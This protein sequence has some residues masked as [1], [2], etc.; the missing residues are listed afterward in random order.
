VVDAEVDEAQRPVL[1]SLMRELTDY[2]LTRYRRR[3]DVAATKDAFVCKLLRNANGDPILKLPPRDRVA[4]PEGERDVRLPDGSVWRFRF[5]KEFCNVAR[6]PGAERNQLPD[7]MRRWFGPTAGAP[8]TSFQLR[9][10]PSPDGLWVEPQTAQ[11]IAFSGTRGTVAAYPDLRAAAG[12]GAS[13]TEAPDREWVSLPI[14]AASDALFAVRVAGNSMDGGRAPLHHGDWAVFRL[15]RGAAPQAVAGRVVLVESPAEASGRR[16]QI[17]RLVHRDG[18]WQLASDNPDGPQLPV[19]EGMIVIAQLDRAFTPDA[20]GPDLGTTIAEPDLARAF[21]LEELAARTGRHAGH[22]FCFIDNKTVLKS[23]TEVAL[24]DVNPRPGETVFA[25]ARRA[26]GGWR[27]L[28]VGRRSED[29]RESLFEIPEVDYETW[30]TWGAGRSASRALPHEALTVAQRMVDQMMDVPEAKRVVTN[31]VGRRGFVRGR[32][33]KGGL[34]LDGG[35]ERFAERTVSLTDLGW[36]AVAAR[37]VEQNGGVLDEARVN[38]LRYLEGT[39]RA[40]TRWIDTG[41]AIAVYQAVRERFG[42]PHDDPT[43]LYKVHDEAGN[44]L[45]ASF[46]VEHRGEQL[47]VVIESRGGTR[48]SANERNTQYAQGLEL[49]LSRLGAMDVQIADALV[50]SAATQQLP[51]EKRRLTLEGEDYPLW[52][53]DPASLRS[54]LGAAQSFVGRAAGAKGSGNSTRRI[55][56]FLAG[57]RLGRDRGT[58]ARLLSG[59]GEQIR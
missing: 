47:T 49:I 29:A 4:V 45:D 8:G 57:E 38:R 6:P 7:L 20:L 19:R 41:W 5:A 50:E 46:R 16:F 13:T 36:V 35:P 1:A 27:Y 10:I 43:A 55:R 53:T 21:G 15:A 39:D 48:G 34:R 23:P 51:I 12:H 18:T 11:V 30:R 14:D 22:L 42:S 54:K 31:P 3:I 37:D 32:A 52:I 40:A 59:V 25:L 9:F 33:Q 2:R 24:P 58:L 28:G 44:E 17:K 56:L 26:E